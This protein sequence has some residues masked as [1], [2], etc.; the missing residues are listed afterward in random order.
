MALQ[1]PRLDDIDL[2]LTDLRLCSGWHAAEAG[3]RW[4]NVAGVID[5][6]GARSLVPHVDSWLRHLAPAPDSAA[7]RTRHASCGA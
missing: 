4:S 7:G 1:A 3:W 6:R 2:P 5:V